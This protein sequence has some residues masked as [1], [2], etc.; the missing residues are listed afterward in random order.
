MATITQRE[1]NVSLFVMITFVGHNHILSV[2]A[3]EF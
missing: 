2:K 1:V 3:K